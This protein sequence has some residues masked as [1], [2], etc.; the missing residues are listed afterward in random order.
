M[1]EVAKP[2]PRAKA[3]AACPCRMGDCPII[4]C[5]GRI[6]SRIRIVDFKKNLARFRPLNGNLSHDFLGHPKNK[7]WNFVA[8]LGFSSINCEMNVSKNTA[9]PKSSILLVFSMIFTLHFGGL[10]PYFWVSTQIYRFNPWGCSIDAAPLK[11]ESC[12]SVCGA[13]GAETCSQDGTRTLDGSKKNPPVK[14]Q[15]NVVFQGGF[16]GLG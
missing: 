15:K 9:T 3:T 4:W 1:C 16:A 8:S 6:T 11:G 7:T 2:I 5:P 10:G 12:T 14:Q 13:A